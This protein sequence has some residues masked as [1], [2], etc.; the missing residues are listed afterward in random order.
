MAEVK[1]RVFL[2]SAT[3]SDWPK[4]LRVA[5]RLRHVNRKSMLLV[6]GYHVSALPR[7]A[8]VEIFDY[9]IVG[10][11][12]VA[13]SRILDPTGSSVK[14]WR[15]PSWSGP[16]VIQAPRITDLSQLPFPLRDVDEIRSNRLS[17]LIFPPTSAQTGAAA[18]VLSRGCNNSCS[19]CSSHTIWGSRLVTRDVDSVIQ[20]YRDVTECLH[21]NAVVFVDQAF[22]ENADW[23]SRL[24]RSMEQL[25]SSAKWYCMAKLTINQK[26]LLE[27]AAAG[28]TKIGFGVETADPE[29]RAEL[30]GFG[31]ESVDDLN[32]LFNACNELGIFV[33]IYL[34]IGFPW[35]TEEYLLRTTRRF[36]QRL[37]ANEL[38][39]SFFTPFPGTRDWSRYRN[40]LV[41]LDWQ[42]FDTVRMPVVHNPGVT[43][44]QYREIRKNL[45]R[46]FY[47][48]STYADVTRRMLRSFPHYLE[49]Y[50]EFAVY[51]RHLEM[52]S[53]NETWLNW[54]HRGQAVRVHEISG[55]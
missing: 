33:K 40:Q 8:G 5:A 3:T 39:I 18:V 26:L 37:Q 20:E 4:I 19:F 17:G 55:G 28:C 27:M 30:K 42:D 46:A 32:H 16:C 31:D 47:G 48:S 52:V 25:K 35:E 2:F 1:P 50:R 7:D 13:V 15:S 9:V 24:C 43:V 14:E 34:M 51:L 53:G 10:E 6:G 12:E 41:T 36:L 54:I 49:S 45:F 11:G 21:A 29:R 44:T 23:T 38:K 22:G